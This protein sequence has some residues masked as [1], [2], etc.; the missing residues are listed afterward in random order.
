M[1]NKSIQDVIVN[2]YHFCIPENVRKKAKPLLNRHILC[3]N[4]ALYNDI[5]ASVKRGEMLDYDIETRY[6]L[7]NG[8][9]CIP[10]QYIEE[11]SDMKVDVLYDNEEM[12]HYVIHNGR[13]LFYPRNYSV[14]KIIESYRQITGEQDVRSPHYYW[15]SQNMPKMG[16]VLVD[17]GSAEGIVALDYVEEMSKVYIIECEE[18][19]IDAL[20][21][22]FKPYK[23][24]VEI[25]PFLCGEELE[26]ERVITLDTLL[27][28]VE[29]P[30]VIKMDIEGGEMSALRGAESILKR[31]D[32]KISVTTYH[33]N[34]AAKE[35]YEYLSQ[36]GYR[37]NFSNGYMLFIYD[38]NTKFPYFRRGV[39]C[40]S[41][42]E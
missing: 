16:D 32:T 20:R 8:L 35:I 41:R 1:S 36:Q 14:N 6:V 30:I 25:I 42:S 23:E 27:S 5:K 33:T 7:K 39:L 4:K 29:S 13:R 38:Y 28:S 9:H 12:K 37:C 18:M 2:I 40:A 15:N 21:A 31:A 34:E 26:N 10:Y 11:Y 19:W 22:T 24:K 3:E 17:V